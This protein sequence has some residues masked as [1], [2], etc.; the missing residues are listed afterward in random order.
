MPLP[1]SLIHHP[2]GDRLVIDRLSLQE[3]IKL[4]YLTD[5]LSIGRVRL[6]SFTFNVKR[7]QNYARRP[8]ERCHRCIALASNRDASSTGR[9]QM[10]IQSFIQTLLLSLISIHH[11]SGYTVPYILTLLPFAYKVS[12]S[13]SFRQRRRRTHTWSLINTLLF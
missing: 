7:A 11:Q 4:V 6:I 13:R 8:L 12:Q 10:Y 2:A 1:F 3:H 5:C 9:K